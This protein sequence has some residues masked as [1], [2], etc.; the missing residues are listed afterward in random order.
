MTKGLV[1][2]V[3]KFNPRLD[4][5]RRAARAKRALLG[6][7]VV[8]AK[9]RAIVGGFLHQ[10]HPVLG[11]SGQTPAHASAM[12]FVWAISVCFCPCHSRFVLFSSS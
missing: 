11:Q 12:R 1:H 5:L 7:M 2:S 9:V 3:P 6:Q 4:L 8:S 10:E